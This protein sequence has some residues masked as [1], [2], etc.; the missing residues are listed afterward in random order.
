LHNW[1]VALRKW[2]NSPDSKP[3]QALLA[4]N[5]GGH[6]LGSEDSHHNGRGG[7][8]T[9]DDEMRNASEKWKER[10]GKQ[11][12]TKEIGCKIDF[13]STAEMVLIVKCEL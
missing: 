1:T 11:E 13:K 6:G 10:R 3:W 8:E 9:H 7:R 12:K 5:R 4:D 2:L